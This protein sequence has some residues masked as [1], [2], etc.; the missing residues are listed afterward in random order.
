MSGSLDLADMAQRGRM[1]EIHCVRCD[2]YGRLLLSKLIAEHGPDLKLPELANI[3][4][5]VCTVAA[6]TTY[7]RC[8]IVFPQLGG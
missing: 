1:L 7:D 6:H 8:Q 2:R 3:L 4:S 5:K